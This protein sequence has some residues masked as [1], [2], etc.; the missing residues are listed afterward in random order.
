MNKAIYRKSM[1]NLRNSIDVKPV[2][3]IKDC[4]KKY[5]KT[6]LYVEQNI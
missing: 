5:I 1:K 3:N 6:K 2:N 4:L